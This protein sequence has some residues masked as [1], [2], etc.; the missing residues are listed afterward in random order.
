MEV[1]VVSDGARTFPL[2]DTFVLNAKK[3]EV[4]AALEKAYMPRE[5]TTIHFAPVVVNNGGKL[6]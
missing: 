5:K 4:N 2:P 6:N 1:A 3:D